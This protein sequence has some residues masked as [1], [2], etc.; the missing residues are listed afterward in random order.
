[1]EGWEER[2]QLTPGSDE[3]GEDARGFES[4]GRV[5]LPLIR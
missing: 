5:E 2:K 4:S 1:M 3:I